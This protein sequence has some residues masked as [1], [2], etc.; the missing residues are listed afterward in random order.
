MKIQKL[1]KTR[2]HYILLGTILGICAGIVVSLFRLGIEKLSELVEKAYHFFP[3]HP[4][5][6]LLWLLIS[7]LCAIVVGLLVKSDPDIKGS[8]IPQVEGQLRDELST[9]WF[10]VLWKKFVG[11]VIS[12][13]MGLFLGREGPS[14]QLGASVGQG[15]AEVTKANS[16]DTKILL[17]SGASA[18]LAA[19]FNAPIAAL[20]FVVEEVHHNFSPLVWLTSFTSAI[21][22]NFVSLTIFGLK[23][24]LHMG[25]IQSLPLNYYGL[26]I[27]L[28]VLLGILGRF[29][30]IVLLKLADWYRHLPLPAH[31]YGLLPFLLVIPIGYFWPDTLGGGNQLVLAFSQGIPPLA[32]LLFLFVLRFSFSMISYGASLPGGIFLPIL[33]LGAVIGGIFGMTLVTFFG[34]DLIYVKT[35]VIIAMAGYFAAIGKAP[36]TAI[37]LVTEMV[38]SLQHLMPLGVVALVAY[39]VVDLLGGSPIY[40]SLLERLVEKQ[41][42]PL[43]GKKV[44]LEFPVFADSPLDGAAVRDISWPEH[45]LLTSLTRG[46][47]EVLIHGDTIVKMGDTLHILTDDTHAGT[48][49][50]RIKQISK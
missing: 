21:V 11:G 31:F 34:M 45:C 29:Y 26:L 2:G 49:F 15:L 44:V 8:G 43:Q 28:G 36:L 40:D 27:I 41:T 19:A 6:L 46:E 22:A 17:S 3:S 35:F 33:S 5:W 24:V 30:Q 32:T 13:G 38:G 20:L 1:D 48:V 7:V 10:S 39:L 16:S 18:G 14:I 25:Q 4:Q 47:Q 9:N 23:P 50:K 37:I 12:V 42:V